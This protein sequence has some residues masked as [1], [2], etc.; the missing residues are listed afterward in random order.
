MVTS[1]VV[2]AVILVIAT[3]GYG[4]GS[5]PKTASTIAPSVPACYAR[6][7]EIRKV[8]EGDPTVRSVTFACL[9]A[10]RRDK[11]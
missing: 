11:L 4:T 2:S 6:A 7:A 9:T 1:S 8:L 10:V 5:T 3:F